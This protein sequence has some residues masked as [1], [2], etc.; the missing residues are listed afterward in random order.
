VA[1]GGE[2]A[3]GREGLVSHETTA[4]GRTPLRLTMFK[5]VRMLRTY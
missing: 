5:W 2:D 1:A 3:P 4:R